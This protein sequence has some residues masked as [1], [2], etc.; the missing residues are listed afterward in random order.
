MKG[1]IILL[2]FKAYRR[3]E[4][5]NRGLEKLLNVNDPWAD[6]MLAHPYCNMN[7]VDLLSA[8]LDK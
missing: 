8:I 1:N 3:T 2:S 5:S 7:P 6:L 4:N